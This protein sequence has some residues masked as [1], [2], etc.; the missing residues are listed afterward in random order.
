MKAAVCS[1]SKRRVAREGRRRCPDLLEDDCS[2]QHIILDLA[3]L[4]S[5]NRIRIRIRIRS[6]SRSR[7]RNRIRIR[8][9]IRSRNRSRIRIRNRSRNRNRN[10]SRLEPIGKLAPEQKPLQRTAIQPEE[11]E[12]AL[13]Y[14]SNEL[15]AFHAKHK[16]KMSLS[17]VQ[18]KVS[19]VF[20][21]KDQYFT[22]LVESGRDTR[23][24][25]QSITTTERLLKLHAT[26]N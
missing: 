3:D 19:A 10:R 16:L 6:R 13:P 8:N 7:N 11:E 15:V 25:R 26:K 22:F 1:H 2:L 20:P 14:A 21:R 12:E 18:P 9:R 24:T 17:E 23:L 5:R 4:R